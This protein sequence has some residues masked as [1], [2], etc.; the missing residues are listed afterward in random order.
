[1]FLRL[2]Y[3]KKSTFSSVK[4][5]V[6]TL[7]DLRNKTSKHHFLKS[8]KINTEPCFPMRL[9]LS[10]SGHSSELSV[11]NHSSRPTVSQ[12]KCVSDTISNWFENHQPQK[13]E[14]STV[15]YAPFN[16]FKTRIKWLLG[17]PQPQV[18][19]R[20]LFLLQFSRQRQSFTAHRAAPMTKTDLIFPAFPSR[21]V[22]FAVQFCFRCKFS[23]H[24]KRRSSQVWQWRDFSRLI[25]ILC[26]GQ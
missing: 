18:F 23:F 25:I 16:S 1:M 26:Y 10:I 5:C 19:P 2:I 15:I 7:I 20:A 21:F 4:I 24:H 13:T 3:F 6:D 8:D 14:I 12:L 17:W 9:F 22:D 11:A